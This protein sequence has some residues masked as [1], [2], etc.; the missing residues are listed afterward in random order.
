MDF[1]GG[2]SGKDPVCQCRLDIRDSRSIPGWGRSPGGEIGNP[3]QYSCLE[4]ST[5][6]GAWQVTVH[7]VAKSQTQLSDWTTATRMLWFSELCI[8]FVSRGCI[9]Y[10]IIFNTLCNI[11]YLRVQRCHSRQ[12]ISVTRNLHVWSWLGLIIFTI[13]AVTDNNL[14]NSNTSPEWMSGL[15]KGDFSISVFFLSISV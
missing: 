2:T 14:L 1:P 9:S 7:G 3:L 8:T 5:D 15:L 6:R 11:V 12:K 13:P 10:F 4:N